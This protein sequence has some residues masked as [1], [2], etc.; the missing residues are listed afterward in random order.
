MLYSTAVAAALQ[1]LPAAALCGR[2]Q[3][4]LPVCTPAGLP[5]C[6]AGTRGAA[7][8]P[9]PPTYQQRAFDGSLHVLMGA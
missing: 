6:A 5:S 3:W 2:L 9:G 4:T 8:H 1:W 7:H